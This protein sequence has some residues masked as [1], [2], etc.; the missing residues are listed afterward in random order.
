MHYIGEIPDTQVKA[1]IEYEFYDFQKKYSNIDFFVVDNRSIYNV[2]NKLENQVVV[3]YFNDT[4]PL[5]GLT[6]FFDLFLNNPKRTFYIITQPADMSRLADW[7][8]NVHWLHYNLVPLSNIDNNPMSEYKNIICLKDKNFNNKQVGIS[9]NR[10]PRDHR[11]VFF[12]YLLGIRLDNYCIITAPLLKWHLTQSTD[13]QDIMNVLNWDFDNHENF[14]NIMLEGWERAKREDGLA[15]ITVDAYPPYDVLEP[16]QTS[17]TNSANYTKN[18]VPLYQNSFVEFVTESV[19]N[20]DLAWVTEKFL[21]SQ[22]GSNFPIWISGKGTVTWLRKHGFDV[23]D[24]IVDHSYDT[25]QDP[26]IR[27]QNCV[28]NNINLFQNYNETKELWTKNKHR[29]QKNVDC[30]FNLQYEILKSSRKKLDYWLTKHVL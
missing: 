4:P 10:L 28:K 5:Q 21:N 8:N 24:D 13:N 16:N 1:F 6:V 14:K 26:V 20:F 23:F 11:L 25:V 30:F 7:P 19:Y 12:S 27:M 17:F 29:F 9:L 2:Q 18:L 22:L 15:P 3:I